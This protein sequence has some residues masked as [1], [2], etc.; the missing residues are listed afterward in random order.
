MA[1]MQYTRWCCQHKQLLSLPQVPELAMTSG[2]A[3]PSKPLDAL[4]MEAT[5]SA[6]S[7][8]LQ[9]ALGARCHSRG[10][11]GVCGAWESGSCL[12][13]GSYTCRRWRRLYRRR[14]WWQRESLACERQGLAII[15]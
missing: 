4:Q 1:S 11:K 13:A 5:V 14:R 2:H 12:T 10:V 7:L 6:C 15:T 9:S 3:V 8:G